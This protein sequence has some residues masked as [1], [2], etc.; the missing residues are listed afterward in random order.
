MSIG[1]HYKASIKRQII[2]RLPNRIIAICRHL[3]L[4]RLS[5]LA[6]GMIRRAWISDRRIVAGMATMP[7]RAS[8]FPVAFRSIVQQVDR[9][10]L[11]LDGHQEVPE[12]ARNDP[13]VIP[14]FS[15]DEP[16]LARMSGSEDDRKTRPAHLHLARQINAVH[17]SCVT[18]PVC[19]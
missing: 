16:K 7:S 19:G 8:T 15:R 12:I 17:A 5:R 11:Y 3:K 13:R 18:G 9:L 6:N 10:Y 1:R 4:S 2:K 14:I